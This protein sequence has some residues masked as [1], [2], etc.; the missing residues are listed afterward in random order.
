MSLVRLAMF[1]PKNGNFWQIFVDNVDEIFIRI[2][3]LAN[4]R[5]ICMNCILFR[6]PQCGFRMA[7][8]S[9][10]ASLYHS[11]MDKNLINLGEGLCKCGGHAT[12]SI[13]SSTDRTGTYSVGIGTGTGSVLLT[14]LAH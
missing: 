3:I 2:F 12:G 5:I 13:G 8:P 4:M 6:H 11:L 10:Q 1:G 7:I 14:V 9:H